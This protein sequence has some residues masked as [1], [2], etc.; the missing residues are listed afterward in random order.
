[1]S[2]KFNLRNKWNVYVYI[3]F[4]IHR[5]EGLIFSVS[6]LGLTIS[7]FSVLLGNFFIGF[8]FALIALTIDLIIHLHKIW[9]FT[10]PKSHQI[11]LKRA[12]SLRGRPDS[13]KLTI[14]KLVLPEYEIKK[15]YVIEKL[16][17]KDVIVVN[18]LLDKRLLQ[19]PN[20]KIVKDR[21]YERRVLNNMQEHLDDVHEF[22]T[23]KSK[24]QGRL[25]NESK[26]A[27]IS[28]LDSDTDEITLGKTSYFTSIITNEACTYVIE[29]YGLISKD[30][31]IL[32]PISFN[33]KQQACLEPIEVSSLMSNDIGISTLAL[34]GDNYLFYWVQNHYAQQSQGLLAPTGSGSLDWKD[35]YQSNDDFLSIIRYGMARELWEES[36][37]KNN[38]QYQLTK[39]NKAALVKN[40]Y[41]IGYFR[42]IKRG[43]RPEFIGISKIDYKSYVLNPDK[44]E[45]TQILADG[46]PVTPI[47]IETVDGAIEMCDALLMG[48]LHAAELST[49][50]NVLLNRLKSILEGKLGDDPKNEIKKLWNLLG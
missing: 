31:R 21:T 24:E 10:E 48:T 49:P 13:C 5:L 22:L 16:Q 35:T 19:K 32:F 34:T 42:W 29:K 23:L 18:D 17:N 3:L 39:E 25:F 26:T 44:L 6:L 45:V 2:F 47:K 36:K 27:I 43:G 11:K 28:S 37:L 41:V 4:K 46:T 15:G 33:K 1:M 12:T 20:I 9:Y 8:L 50:L 40:T 7:I 30:F 38:E 14:E